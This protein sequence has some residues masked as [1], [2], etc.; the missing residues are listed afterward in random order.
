M[1]LHYGVELRRRD[2]QQRT[3]RLWLHTKH[4]CDVVARDPALTQPKRDGVRQRKLGKR[5][6]PIHASSMTATDVVAIRARLR[7]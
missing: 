2:L 7:I 5:T 3:D 6:V 1:V 4:V